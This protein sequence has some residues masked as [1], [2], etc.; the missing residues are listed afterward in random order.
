MVYLVI[1]SC[2]SERRAI[3]IIARGKPSTGLMRFGDRV[4]MQATDAKGACPLGSIE[5]KVVRAR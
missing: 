5:Q 1:P 2:I 3:E 4:W